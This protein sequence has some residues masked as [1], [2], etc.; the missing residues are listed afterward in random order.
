MEIRRELYK[1]GRTEIRRNERSIDGKTT[2]R[3]R[4]G[5]EG[6]GTRKEKGRNRGCQQRIEIRWSGR[7]RERWRMETEK[8]RSQAYKERERKE[9]RGSGRKRERMEGRRQG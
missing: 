3:K 9:K 5:K 4:E 6:W 1:E 2:G 8:R 7:K